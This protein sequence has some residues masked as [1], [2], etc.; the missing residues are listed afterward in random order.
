MLY[1][2]MTL[3][4]MHILELIQR[5]IN[6]ES[7]LLSNSQ[8][9]LLVENACCN[10]GSKITRVYFEEKENSIR[11]VNNNVQKYGQI[12][13]M[14][15]DLIMPF[16]LFDPLNTKLKYPAVPK[17]FSENTIY[18]AFIRFCYY[19][20]GFILSEQLERVCG[21]N[22]SAFKSTNDISEKIEILKREGKNYSIDDFLRLM[23]IVNKSNIRLK[24]LSSMQISWH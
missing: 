8:N 2:K 12:Y 7:L 23:N 3:M 11:T 21:T 9:E 18:R 19:N 22:A 15:E 4:S 13:N 16:Y 24:C 1:G 6:K 5:V 14:V 10:N 17:T 20:T